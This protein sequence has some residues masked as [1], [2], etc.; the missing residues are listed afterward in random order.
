[1]PKSL[2]K[3]YNKMKDKNDQDDSSSITSIASSTSL[4][5]VDSPYELRRRQGRGGVYGGDDDYDPKDD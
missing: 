5:S 1:V 3:F 4:P 2:T